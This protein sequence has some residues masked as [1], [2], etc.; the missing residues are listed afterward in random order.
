MQN[1]C[2][3]NLCY[4]CGDVLWL[5][6]AVLNVFPRSL[7]FIQACIMSDLTIIVDFLKL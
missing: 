2:D 6:S 4:E 5:D 1:S 7:C 3:V